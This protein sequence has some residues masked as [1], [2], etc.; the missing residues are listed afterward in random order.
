MIARPTP[1]EFAP[2]YAGYVSKVPQSGPL[3]ALEA[4]RTAI[5]SLASLPADTATFRYEPGK[6]SV[7]EVLGHLA[8]AERVFAY[9]LLRVARNDATPLPGFDENQ[10]AEVAPH[11]FRPIAEVVAEL[12]AVREATLPL[13]RTL[14]DAML[15]RQ[16][17]ANGRPV[18]G[19][20]LCWITA[21]H[22]Q[23][24]L[25]ILRERYHAGA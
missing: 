19:R 16:V 2:F 22:T 13:V 5:A 8:D 17:V 6:W 20:A 9:R 12:L 21:G 18:S 23:H 14:N 3:A 24:H 11:H 4:Q 10:W 25:D 1:E 15:T 7:N